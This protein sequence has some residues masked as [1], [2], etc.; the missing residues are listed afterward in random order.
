MAF[1]LPALLQKSLDE[2][3]VEYKNLGS[4]GLKI[5]VPILGAMGLGSSQWLPWVLEEEQSLEIL[6]AAYDRG[7]NTWDTANFYS[8][9]DSEVVI[10]KAMKKFNI[11]R[12]KVVLMTKCALYVSEDPTMMGVFPQMSQSKDYVNQGGK[13]HIY[14]GNGV[15]F[16]S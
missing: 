6:K 3:K 9:G 10:G 15:E 16:V 5:S 7:I 13:P 2:T 8:N 14:Y 12:E 11:P 1:Q 4:S